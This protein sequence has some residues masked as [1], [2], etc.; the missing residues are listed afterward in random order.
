MS[1][2]DNPSREYRV[3]IVPSEEANAFA[4][5]G[6]HIVFLSGLVKEAGSE[7]ELAMVLGHELGHYLERDHLQGLGRGLVLVF[8]SSLLFGADSPLASLTMA[9]LGGA[10]MQFSQSQERQA[11][12]WGLKLLMEEYGHAGG[13]TS[14]FRRMEEEEKGK[15]L[16]YFFSTH[17]FPRERIEAMEEAILQR[18][19]PVKETEAL[20]EALTLPE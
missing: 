13:A 2:L 11:D 19:Y 4:L 18:G 9:L 10:E 20:G 14:F 3:H 5:P 12:E 1:H 15:E 17:P 7:N 8:L 6:G 16:L